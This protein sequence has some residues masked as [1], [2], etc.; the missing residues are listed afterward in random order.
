MNYIRDLRAAADAAEEVVDSF[1]RI[2]AKIEQVQAA[3]AAPEEPLTFGRLHDLEKGLRFIGKT[4]YSW[5]LPIPL[6]LAL[7]EAAKKGVER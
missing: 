4:S 7:V 3:S 6:L 1:R 2:A 5:E